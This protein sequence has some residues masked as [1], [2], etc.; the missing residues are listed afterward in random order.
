MQGCTPDRANA[1]DLPIA[2]SSATRVALLR[3]EYNTLQ[4]PDLD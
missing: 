1:D 4:Y 3:I 2:D